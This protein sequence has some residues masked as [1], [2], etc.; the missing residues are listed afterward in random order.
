[1]GTIDYEI[2]ST[3]ELNMIIQH[4][5]IHTNQLHV[6]IIILLELL[7]LHNLCLQMFCLHVS[8]SHMSLVPS[9]ARIK[10]Q[11]PWTW[12]YGRLLSYQV[13]YKGI[14]CF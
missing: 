13:L 5:T 6:C 10:H 3:I 14:K 4:V 12:T 9:E 8:A 11:V 7:G 1:M 2:H